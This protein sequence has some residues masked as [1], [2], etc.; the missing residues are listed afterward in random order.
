MK[1]TVN[2]NQ[3]DRVVKIFSSLYELAEKFAEEMVIMI[4]QSASRGKNITIALSG[5][6]TPELLYTLIIEKYSHSVPWQHVHFF[7]GDERC[8]APDNVESNFG[9]ARDKLLSKIEIP[10]A[11]IHRIRGEEDPIWEAGRYSDEI[12]MFSH[13][14]ENIPSFDLILLGLG[15]DGHTASLFPGHPE[16]FDSDK[17]CEVATHPATGQ[18]RITL[19]GKVINNADAV[20]F[21][22]SGKKKA[23][24]VEKLF[25]NDPVALKY[26]SNYI[27]PVYG[28]LSW[29]IDQEAGSLL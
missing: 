10:S 23:G 12:V 16:L 19:T 22:V 13:I 7:W 20:V 29:F 28:R 1:C 14:R 17:I 8:V 21:L 5:G 3:L 4:K 18:K 15:E 24:V 27:V 25:K 11:N 26:P 2:Y 9:M 6:S